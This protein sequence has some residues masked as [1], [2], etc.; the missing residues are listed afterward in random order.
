[1]R[2]SPRVAER[3]SRDFGGQHSSQVLDILSSLDLGVSRMERD[4]RICGAIL[5][6]AHGDVDLL[7]STA[8]EAE[9][10]WR[11]VLVSAGLENDDWRE[12]LDDAL[13]PRSAES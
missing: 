2:I 1:M 9:R 6:I 12:R 11:D 8:A 3:T 5:I 4:E 13:T 10:D 7:V